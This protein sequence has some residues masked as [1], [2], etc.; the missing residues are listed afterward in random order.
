MRILLHASPALLLLGL[1]ASGC[2]KETTTAA[3]ATPEKSPVITSSAAMPTD[4][5]V[6]GIAASVDGVTL[7]RAELMQ[8]V[9]SVLEAR[10]VPEEQQ[11]MASQYFASSMVND[12]VAKTLLLGEVRHQKL[13]INDAERKKLL[14]PF[15]EMAAKQ[16]TTLEDMIKKMPGGEAK[17]R[18]ELDD[19]LLIEKLIDAQVRS[20]LPKDEKTLEAAFA[21]KSKERLA[22]REQIDTIRTQLL[23]GTNFAELA[24]DMSDCPSGKQ[25]GGDLGAFERERMVKPFAEAAFS[26]KIGEIGPVVETDFGFHVIKV[27]ARNEAKAGSGAT[28]ATPETVQASHILIKAPPAM[29]REAFT[30]EWEDKQVGKAMQSYLAGLRA[31]AKITTIF[32]RPAG[33]PNGMPPGMGMPE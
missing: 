8:Q 26:Q 7:S 6:T 5:T 20:K 21:E 1:C 29:N 28:P 17:A 33:A 30:K 18:Q 10:Q 13:A 9:Q 24:R 31:K 12:F 2:K 23:A 16:G 15:E 3:T 32:D 25:A 4:N 14:L 11:A 27:T 19:Q 22:K